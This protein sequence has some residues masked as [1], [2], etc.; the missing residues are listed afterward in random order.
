MPTRFENGLTVRE[1]KEL[2]KDWPEENE[3]GELC[4]V[5]LGDGRGLSNQVREVS[6]L[7]LRTTD[8]STYADLML[9]HD[10]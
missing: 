1:L 4:E 6:P 10:G 3:E 8:S 5:W 2:V 7:N 9:S